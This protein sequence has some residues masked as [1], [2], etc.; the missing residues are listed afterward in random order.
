MRISKRIGVA[1][2]ATAALL[3]TANAAAAQ[4]SLPKVSKPAGVPEGLIQEVQSIDGRTLNADQDV[5]GWLG[6][7]RVILGELLVAECN[8]PHRETRLASIL[9][10]EFYRVSAGVPA[11]LKCIDLRYMPPLSSMI[12]YA[13]MGPFPA[14]QALIRIGMPSVRAIL[15]VLPTERS[16]LRR[17]LM[18]PVMVGVEGRAV[19]NFRLR[20]AIAKATTAAAKANLKAAL[21]D[22]PLASHHHALRK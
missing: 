2:L 9:L 12:Y 5:L 18:V 21:H 22:V 11:L 20:R 6:Q 8:S 4:I 3:L 14:E 17:K 19:T 7:Q 1:H 15:K 16:A 10:I 13:P